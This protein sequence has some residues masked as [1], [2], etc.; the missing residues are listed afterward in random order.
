IRSCRLEPVD[1]LQPAAT[2]LRAVR[3]HFRRRLVRTGQSG[4]L[5]ASGDEVGDDVRTG[6]AGSPGDEN[7]HGTAPCWRREKW[8]YGVLCREGRSCSSVELDE[9]LEDQL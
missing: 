5:V 2:S 9:I 1:I 6:M 4:D 7:A 3:G 8:G